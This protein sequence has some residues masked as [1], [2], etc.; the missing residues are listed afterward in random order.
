MQIVGLVVVI[1]VAM[2]I[3]LPSYEPTQLS[4]A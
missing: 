2:E 3:Q 1:T 4:A